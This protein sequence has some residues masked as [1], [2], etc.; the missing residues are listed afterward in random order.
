M[1]PR[2]YRM[3][4]TLII[5]DTHFPYQHRDTFKFLEAAKDAYGCTQAKHT[6]DVVDYSA[7][8]FHEVEYGTLSPKQEY[9]A[10][11]K[12]VQKLSELFPV[13]DVVVGNHDALPMRKA[14]KYGIPEDALKSYNDVF[15]VNWTWKDKFYFPVENKNDNCLLVH[16]MGANTLS[17]ARNHSHHSIQGHHH[18]KFGIEY[19]G[20]T[21]KLRWSMTVGCLIDSAHPA[22]NYASK[23]TLNRPIIG[24]GAI[25]ENQPVLIPMTLNKAGR[26]NNKI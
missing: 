9:E 19:F 24:C 7:S 25:I 18:G 4:N 13:L 21:E 10:S 11:Y 8:S 1:K 26:W 17:N 14:T 23:M 6:G 15:D 20:D 3:N 5:S 2:A 22:F 16:S 12:A